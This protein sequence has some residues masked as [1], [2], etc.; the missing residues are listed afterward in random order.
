MSIIINIF[1]SIG[2]IFIIGVL[3]YYIYVYIK[4]KSDEQMIKNINP[5]GA[6]MQN[7]GIKCPDYWVNTGVDKDGN[8][9]CRNSFNIESNLKKSDGTPN[10]CNFNEMTF[11][12]LP[13]GKTWEA[14]NPNGMTS[15]T[16][17]EKLNFLKRSI[18]GIASLS[19]CD[20]VTSCGPTS[21]IPGVWSGVNEI[22]T[23]G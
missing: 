5:P 21:S 13:D 20:W 2:F 1:A 22:C 4:K 17:K 15:L 3:I 23:S 12:K 18:E 9:I 14:N 7:T 19:R 16:D 11:A 10:N 8:Y 6:Y